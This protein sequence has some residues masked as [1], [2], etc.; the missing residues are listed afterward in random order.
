M[1]A[2]VGGVRHG[3]GLRRILRAADAPC[4]C[5]RLIREGTDAGGRAGHPGRGQGAPMI[6]ADQG[7]GGIQ[8]EVGSRSTYAPLWRSLDRNV[9][10]R[11]KLI[12]PVIL[13][14][15]LGT[16]GFG[17]AEAIRT[18]NA[19][20]AAYVESATASGRAAAD[21]FYNTI[22]VPPAVDQY[23][24]DLASAEPNVRGIWIVNLVLPGAPA[25]AS[26]HSTSI[27]STGL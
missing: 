18:N 4:R 25:V 10:L 3:D 1:L 6:V 13:V 21:A 27:S 16:G 19:V 9:P 23:L 7:E 14:T 5:G 11:L 2:S 20:E 24:A 15:L 26:S 17:F 8:P 22:N 12:V